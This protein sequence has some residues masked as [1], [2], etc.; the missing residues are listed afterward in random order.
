MWSDENG[1]ESNRENQQDLESEYFA[2]KLI[3]K[4][5]T[6]ALNRGHRKFDDPEDRN[7]VVICSAGFDLWELRATSRSACDGTK[8][9]LSFTS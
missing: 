9:V 4:T 6:V 5:D 2:K 3:G 7:G 8:L 1:L